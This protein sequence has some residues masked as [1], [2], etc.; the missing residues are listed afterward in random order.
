MELL[1]DLESNDKESVDN[2]KQRL[3]E[4]FK[5]VS[6]P[7]LLNGIYD[8]YLKTNSVRSMD[9]LV[10][11][12]E[13][14]HQFL[15]ERLCESLRS[16]ELKTQALILLGH[17]ARTQPTWL[18]TLPDHNL[19]KDVLKLLKC[20]HDLLPLISALLLVI[21]LLPVLPSKMANYLQDLFEVFSRLAS[22]N[23]SPG[24]FEEDQM[25]HMQVAL[26]ALFLRLYGMYPCNFLNYLR[27][28][29]K[30]KNNPV[31]VHTIKPMLA[32]V[33]MNPSLVTAS[34]DNET[35]TERWKKMGV[36]DV[37]VECERFSLD[38][39]DRC[40][41]DNCQL[42][43]GFRSRSGTSNSTIE[44]Y[45]LQ[46]LKSLTV[47]TPSSDGNNFF[48]PSK[49]FHMETPE[50]VTAPSAIPQHHAISASFPSQ[51]GTS[52]PEAA[53]EATPET[54]PIRDFLHVSRNPPLNSKAV[55]ALT[56][57]KAISGSLHTTPTH[58][59]PSSPM[60]KDV[61]AFHFPDGRTTGFSTYKKDSYAIQKLGK[62]TLDRMQCLDSHQEQ[63]YNLPVP[64]S[65]RQIIN[66]A[67]AQL[68]LKHHQRIESPVS[69]E[70]EEVL[71]IVS[72]REPFKQVARQCDSVLPEFDDSSDT[73]IDD[74]E[75]GSPC[76]AG[77]LHIPNSKS[78]IVFANQI[79]RLRH[80]SQCSNMEA[81]R[82][83]STTGSSPGNGTAFPDNATVRRTNSCP[84]MKKSP[85]A[86]QAKES[87]DN[88]LVETDED[89]ATV[90]DCPSAQKNSQNGVSV[91]PRIST[92]VSCTTQTESFWPY[93]FLFLGI[94]PSLEAGEVKPS[95]AP[96]PAPFSYL[97]DRYSPSIYDILD[98]YVENAVLGTEKES[99]YYLKE[100]LQLVRLQLL[101]ERH[102]RETH[103]YRNRRLLS[104]AK[105][106]RLLE[107][108]NSALRDQVQLQ[109]TEIDNLRV[110]LTKCR[111]EYQEE[112][113]K[114]VEKLNVIENQCKQA[115]VE[116]KSLKETN[117]SYKT[118][119]GAV[120]TRCNELDVQRQ[121]AEAS[122]FD[123]LA[124]RNVAREQAKAGERGR[125]ELEQVNKELLLM[126]ELH[127]KFQEKLNKL[128][129]MQD[130]EQRSRQMNEAYSQEIKDV[131]AKL[132]STV[133]SLQAHQARLVDLEKVLGKKENMVEAQKQQLASLAEENIQ[134]IQAVE[135][136]YQCQLRI[137]RALEEK[138]LESRQRRNPNSP[139]TS[140]CHEVNATTTD[141][142]TGGL[143]AHSSPL[144]ASLASSE[145]S[146]AF[147]EAREVKNLQAL[148]D[149]KEASTSKSS[150]T[151]ENSPVEGENPSDGHQLLSTSS[152]K[153]D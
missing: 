84:D 63:R 62:L 21:V 7:W 40:P 25:I 92:G 95:P 105:S 94:F 88:T 98:K 80:H 89:G 64:S 124:D 19:F 78:M 71:S 16:S 139:D 120:K 26:F 103:A 112:N 31:F 134:K 76:A 9:V 68:E 122:Y 58:S 148:V 125:T 44:S 140:S 48:T 128:S 129:S 135:S 56:T 83:E 73:L 57:F 69:Q 65:P 141:R 91:A 85:A 86:P 90:S 10:N 51:E 37:I 60:R 144:S 29:Y 24:K 153:N 111:A 15:F 131:K 6:D 119:L 42:T 27:N 34:R 5:N 138:L 82:N 23:C 54:T 43:M 70:D 3:R 151:A 152:Q 46:S 77:G 4:Q 67:V 66:S 99:I 143:S 127:L 117:V 14:H 102:R 12:K 130:Y 149:Q 35:T 38:M 146:V 118:E 53:I 49:L 28:Q 116:C 133:A 13:P 8:Y 150:K 101:F 32:N 17:V 132:N 100:Q 72:G 55:R 108:C 87:L 47:K 59:Q 39:T 147:H 2:A 20:E 30:E 137:N 11:I 113:K 75:H 1:K 18:Y 45:Q 22:W 61:G 96:S 136:K 107:E 114:M 50:M 79:K 52:P 106:T 33:K 126:G 74:Q 109:Q 142:T 110:Q 36:H 97:Q 41:H 104:D 145:G 81:D 93:Q 123:A 115:Q 121:Q